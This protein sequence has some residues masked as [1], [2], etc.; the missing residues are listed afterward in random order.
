VLGWHAEPAAISA[1]AERSGAAVSNA[2]T[3]VAA[4]S[5][6][7]LVRVQVMTPHISSEEEDGGSRAVT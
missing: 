4:L 6:M 3:T 5:K 1:L 2:L 7:G